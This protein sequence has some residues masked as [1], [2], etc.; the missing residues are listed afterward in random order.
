MKLATLR[1]HN[2]YIQLSIEKFANI[3]NVTLEE[4]VSMSYH[5]F[6]LE[7]ISFLFLGF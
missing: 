6:N 3:K 4:A 2:Y 1:A 7:A 5:I